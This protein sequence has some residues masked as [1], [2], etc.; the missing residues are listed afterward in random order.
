MTPEL[1]TETYLL[2]REVETG[3]VKQMHLVGY[4]DLTS[5][6]PEGPETEARK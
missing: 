3:R 4:G 2:L 6:E 5:P 1:R